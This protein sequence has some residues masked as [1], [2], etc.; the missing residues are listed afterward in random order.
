MTC[1]HLATRN[2][3]LITNFLRQINWLLWHF[4]K[5]P[6]KS[7]CLLV[8]P[9][10]ACCYHSLSKAFLHYLIYRPPSESNMVCLPKTASLVKGRSQNSIC[11]VPKPNSLQKISRFS[12]D[13]HPFHLPLS[14]SWIVRN[15]KNPQLDIPQF[16]LHWAGLW[17]HGK[18][19]L[20]KCAK[21]PVLQEREVHMGRRSKQLPQRHIC[22]DSCDAE[23]IHSLE[24]TWR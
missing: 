16:T 17:W 4:L 6:V 1:F 22:S 5:E 14:F 9:K 8:K 19:F 2:E 10:A 11:L 7:L 12:R 15:I 18:W 23:G 3:I 21:Q 13:L 24:C 20:G